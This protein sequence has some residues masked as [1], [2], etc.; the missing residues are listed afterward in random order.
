MVAMTTFKC[1]YCKKTIEPK[2]FLDNGHPTR[3]PFIIKVDV[4][5]P[6]TGIDYVFH[7]HQACAE[8]GYTALTILMN[9]IYAGWERDHLAQQEALA[10]ANAEKEK[11]KPK[12]ALVNPKHA[13]GGKR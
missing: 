11:G 5:S 3:E 1:D 9:E 2:Q 13:H 4:D 8:K 7:F 12:I 10:K 6:Y